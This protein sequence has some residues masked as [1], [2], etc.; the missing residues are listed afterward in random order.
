MEDKKD[1]KFQNVADLKPVETVLNE[2]NKA[3]EDEELNIK[4]SKMSKILTGAV[5]ASLGGGI[6]GGI[7]FTALY[8]GGSIV[9]LSAAGMTSGLAAAGA[10]VGGGML[11]GIGVLAFPAVALA[12]IG[13]GIALGK[14]DKRNLIELKR[15]YYEE[16][17]IKQ[18]KIKQLL[19][20]D[21]DEE[22]RKYLYAL[23]I[24]LEAA[25]KDLANDL[26][27]Y[28]SHSS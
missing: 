6:G 17:L 22:R 20:K 15:C 13:T 24:L 19:E 27:I 16:A 14:F 8:F 21:I 1:M 5:G 7:G 2:V 25:I 28:N 9:G 3:I 12:S 11:A 4:T 18:D 26:G 10:L 23:N